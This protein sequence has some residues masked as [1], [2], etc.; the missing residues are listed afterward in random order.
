MI[1]ACPHC[2]QPGRAVSARTIVHHA[3][4]IAARGGDLTGWHLCPSGGECE[5]VYFRG[6]DVVRLA[7][8]RLAPYHKGSGRDRTVCFCFGHTERT[9]ADEVARTGRSAIAEAVRDACR[10]GRGDCERENPLGRCCLGDVG[11]IVD[12]AV[13]DES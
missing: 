12:G 4:G 13:S 7:E 10:Q 11:R 2:H 3:P 5:V 1:P 8:A 6:E 9:V